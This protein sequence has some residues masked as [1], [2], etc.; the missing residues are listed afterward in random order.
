ML[1][2][3]AVLAAVLGGTGVSVWQAFRATRAEADAQR[4]AKAARENARLARE[5]V[6]RFFTRTSEE[7]LLNQPQMQTL[8]KDLLRIAR[9]YYREF[10]AGGAGDP[11]LVL[12]LGQAMFRL[13]RIEA[14][15]GNPTLGL[16][17]LDQAVALYSRL[18]DGSPVEAQAKL[19]LVRCYLTKGNIETTVASRRAA[20]AESYRTALRLGKELTAT[21]PDDESRLE[22]LAAAHLGMAEANYSDPAR[23][24]AEADRAAQILEGLVERRP[25]SEGYQYELA[26]VYHRLGNMHLSSRRLG[27]ARRAYEQSRDH[28]RRL[29]A[30]WPNNPAYQSLEKS[31]LN[32]LAAIAWETGRRD[33][34][35]RLF[36]EVWARTEKLARDFPLTV[37]Y[38]FHLAT[39]FTNRGTWARDRGRIDEA[40]GHFRR[41]Q[42]LLGTLLKAH[43]DSRGAFR[44]GVAM[45]YHNFALLYQGQGR[46][47]EAAPLWENAVAWWD[48]CVRER[49][50]KFQAVR[51]AG[52]ACHYL[53]QALAQTGQP[54][55]AIEWFRRAV[56]RR[57]RDAESNPTDLWVKVN[58]AASLAWV[59]D[60]AEVVRLL[61]GVAA[62]PE[63]ASELVYLGAGVVAFAAA[64][65]GAAAGLYE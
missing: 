35:E 15:T 10:V 43:P 54:D 13:A 2:A 37:E 39:S 49:D 46:W 33:E 52:W 23:Y 22:L 18:A 41:A 45:T 47:A 30:R 26:R 56:E 53:G 4:E 50:T 20:G 3:A 58:L 34:A 16:S 42:E 63:A 31:S 64:R 14:D 1:A 7:M 36:A 25:D 9:D 57:R 55:R 11:E 17:L 28:C 19:E 32:D 12:E 29:T 44:G 51:F 6:S 65:S 38:Q 62:N 5:A 40:E 59:G 21:S 60:H 48:E 27:E 61:R 8:R 24:P